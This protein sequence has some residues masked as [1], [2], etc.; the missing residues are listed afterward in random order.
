MTAIYVPG[1]I[2]LSI[3]KT[4]RS[5]KRKK[6]MSN[7]C[8]YTKG[9]AFLTKGISYSVYKY[10]NAMKKEKYWIYC[11]DILHGAKIEDAGHTRE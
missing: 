11:N 9:A 5:T 4:G 2:K 10:F 8:K 1:R 6:R 7:D 3:R